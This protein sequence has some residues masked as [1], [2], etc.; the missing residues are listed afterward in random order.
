[1]SAASQSAY[2]A[3][4]PLKDKAVVVSGASGG[5]GYVALPTIPATR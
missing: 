3:D 2:R 1:V 5:I 4:R